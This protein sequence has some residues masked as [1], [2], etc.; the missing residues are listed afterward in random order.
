MSEAGSQRENAF[1][2]A[3]ANNSQ[4]QSERTYEA[5]S[6]GEL[7][8]QY[9]QQGNQQVLAALYMR[10]IHLLNGVC[11]KYLKDPATAQ[12][13]CTDIYTELVTKLRRHEVEN[14]KAWLHT[15]AK[16]HCRMKLRSGKKMPVSGLNEQF[17]QMGDEPHLESVR[18]R[19][20]KLEVMERC[21]EELKEEQRRMVRLFY[22][23]EKCYNEICELTGE[24]WNTVRSQIQNGR[25]NLKLCMEKNGRTV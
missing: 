1:I 7:V 25:R 15:L 17:V 12:D 11:L 4:L 16:N 18:Q 14:V 2:S 8:M 23:E 21:L 5:M 22:L 20:E 24:A 13:A 10:Y 9:S 3:F 19:E 6:D